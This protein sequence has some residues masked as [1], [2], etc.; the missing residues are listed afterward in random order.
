MNDIKVD[1]TSIILELLEIKSIVKTVASVS[2]DREE[3]RLFNQE[4]N[5]VFRQEISTF[6]KSHPNLSHKLSDLKNLDVRLS[7]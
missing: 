6:S 5:T 7:F 1:I 2:M 4:V 3:K